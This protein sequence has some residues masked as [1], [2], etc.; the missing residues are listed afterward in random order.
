MAQG[1]TRQEYSVKSAKWAQDEE[2]ITLLHSL[3]SWTNMYTHDKPHKSEM[4]QRYDY[5]MYADETLKFMKYLVDE[6]ITSSQVVLDP[7]D[8]RRIA[9]VHESTVSSAALSRATYKT[10]SSPVHTI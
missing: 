9:H 5:Q 4:T 10:Q 8:L 3:P 2:F 7:S 1:F 6:D